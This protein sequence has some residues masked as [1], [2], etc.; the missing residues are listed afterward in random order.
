MDRGILYGLVVLV[1]V[2]VF[3]PEFFP[4]KKYKPDPALINRI[5]SL[6]NANRELKQRFEEYDSIQTELEQGLVELDIKISN[7]KGKTT[8][9]REVYKGKGNSARKFTPSQVDSFFRDRYNF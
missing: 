5:D 6:E 8:I 4:V 7:T 2:Y 3:L 9:I 1:L